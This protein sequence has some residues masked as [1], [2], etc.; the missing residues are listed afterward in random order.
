M[1]EICCIRVIHIEYIKYMYYMVY[2]KL[3]K[4]RV[5]GTAKNREEES[6]N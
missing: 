4:K 5:K 6:N 3:P 1:L 2:K